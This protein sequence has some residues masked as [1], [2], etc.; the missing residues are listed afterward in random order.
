MRER[1]KEMMKK[2]IAI[3]LLT[4]FLMVTLLPI[5]VF[6]ENIGKKGQVTSEDKSIDQESVST[7]KIENQYSQ[8]VPLDQTSTEEPN[9]SKSVTENGTMVESKIMDGTPNEQSAQLQGVENALS[10]VPLANVNVI[11]SGDFQYIENSNSDTVSIIS[12]IGSSEEIDVPAKIEGKSV[13]SVMGLA[14][15]KRIMKEISFAEGIRKIDDPVLN[16]CLNLKKLTLPSTLEGNISV[17]GTALT[18]ADG[19]KKATKLDKIEITNSPITDIS[20]LNALSNLVY[21]GLGNN[22]QLIDVSPLKNLTKLK[23]INLY[24]SNNIS[25]E[26]IASLIRTEDIKLY[27]TNGGTTIYTKPE[28]VNSSK[29]VLADEKFTIEIAKKDI[30]ETRKNESVPYWKIIPLKQGTTKAVFKYDGKETGKE[31]NIEVVGL[32]KDPDQ[33]V[34]EKVKDLPTIG[35]ASAPG[36]TETMALYDNGQLWNISDEKNEKIMDNVKKY[37]GSSNYINT[38]GLAWTMIEDNNGTLWT[39]EIKGQDAPVVN[40]R[41]ENV[42]KYIG[43]QAYGSRGIINGYALDS[44]KNLWN[45]GGNNT[46]TK[47]QTSVKDFDALG[48]NGDMTGAAVLMEN[49][50]LMVRLHETTNNEFVKLE[51]GVSSLEE[52]EHFVK[53]GEYYAYKLNQETGS[54]EVAKLGNS[55]KKFFSGNQFGIKTEGTTWYMDNF[56]NKTYSKLLDSELKEYA[57]VFRNDKPGYLLLDNNNTLWRWENNNTPEKMIIEKIADNISN[58]NYFYYMDNAQNVY[59]LEGNKIASNVKKGSTLSGHDNMVFL[60]TDNIVY[61]NDVPV[62]NNVED[63]QEKKVVDTSAY[64]ANRLLLV[65]LD[66][67]V[68]AINNTGDPTPYKLA[69]YKGGVEKLG[70]VNK[71]GNIN[72]SDGLLTLRHS[73]KEIVLKDSDFT[74]GDV[75]KDNVVNASDGLQILRYSVKEINSF[76]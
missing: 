38:S 58:L 67:T 7:N 18:S 39:R 73:V 28:I 52:D 63:I 26:S 62:L 36:H 49:G 21:V 64:G 75:N 13:Y 20:G 8:F 44:A 11:T 46:T 3:V 10:P 5:S 34:G 51:S 35:T 1:K 68:W 9:T 42:T 61:I 43:V 30:A 45:L 47:I 54:V 66:G 24:E 17:S 29:N 22:S 59:S 72:A 55:M 70:D 40:K 69:D 23:N 25:A 2:R 37:V 27:T 19:F 76:D 14:S 31:F 15:D 12:Y 16:N 6:A 48:F 74:R 57:S 50:E 53:D 4:V 65:R 32:S 41:V 60:K 71:D 56:N 33:P